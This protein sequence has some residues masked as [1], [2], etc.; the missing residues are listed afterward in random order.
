[1]K[2]I[3]RYTNFISI[4]KKIMFV[5]AI[6]IFIT[7]IITL[8]LFYIVMEFNN[9][10][11]YEQVTSNILLA[12][13]NLSQKFTTIQQFSSVIV[14]DKEIQNL[15]IDL[16]DV[17]GYTSLVNAIDGISTILSIYY[18]QLRNFHVQYLLIDGQGMSAQPYTPKSQLLPTKIKADLLTRAQDSY[19]SFYVTEYS[20]DY[21]IFLVYPIRRFDKPRFDYLG[22]LIIA[23]NPQQLF[24]MIVPERMNLNE[25][26]YVLFD[27][28]FNTIYCS[29]ALFD[30]SKLHGIDYKNKDYSILGNADDPYMVIGRDIFLQWK[31]FTLLPYKDVLKTSNLLRL[32]LILIVSAVGLLSVRITYNILRNSFSKPIHELVVNMKTFGNSIEP[33]VSIKDHFINRKD[34]I[35][36]LYT[37]FEKMTRDILQLVEVNYKNELLYKESQLRYLQAQ[38]HPHFLFNT[39]DSINWRAK[40]A[41]DSVTTEIV[42]SLSVLLRGSLS[43]KKYFTMKE[44]IELVKHYLNIQQIRYGDQLTYILN[45]KEAFYD[46]CFPHMVLQP[47]IE[48][49]IRYSLE[50]D[51]EQCH[52]QIS[53]HR[54]EDELKVRIQNSGSQFE[55]NLLHKLEQKEV[56]VS[57]FGIGLLNIQ[58]RIQLNY[59]ESYGLQ[60]YN[61]QENAVVQIAIPC[62]RKEEVDAQN[63]D[64]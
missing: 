15:L 29:D 21:G 34:E 54:D 16:K 63:D 59:G 24:S 32:L 47:I 20:E 45:C 42:E 8:G 44:E 40:L 52:I 6:S 56:E 60:L 53:A 18:D 28:T 1:M 12:T 37:T 5:V 19:G 30:C 55:D 41:G 51:G 2:V 43:E 48:N 39:L 35:G 33:L 17:G 7:L 3:G 38:I 49:A 26:K 36:A 13:E 57:G 61:D 4:R 27:S 50:I 58:Q 62:I 22:T 14:S 9:H 25:I 46:F 23:I 64:C 10:Q 11:L 31:L